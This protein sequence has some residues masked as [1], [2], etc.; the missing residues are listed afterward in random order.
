MIRSFLVLRSADPGFHV[1]GLQTVRI[2]LPVARYSTPGRQALFFD[3]FLERVRAVPGVSRRRGRGT[4][5]VCRAGTARA[6]S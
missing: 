5:A 4:A 3:R 1:A 2:D 6:A